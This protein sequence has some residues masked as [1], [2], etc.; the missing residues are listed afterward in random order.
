MRAASRREGMESSSHYHCSASTITR[1][2]GRGI[3]AASAYRAGERIKDQRTGLCHDYTRKRGVLHS[4]IVT[5]ADA[6]AWTQDRAQLW[7]AAERAEDSST[8]RATAKTGREFRLAF[9]HQLTAE[10]RIACAREFARYLVDA[11][12]IAVDFSIHAPDRNGDQRNFHAHVLTSTRVMTDAGFGDKVRVLDRPKTSSKHIEAIRAQ[13]AEIE[14]A[15]YARAGIDLRVDYR[16]YERRGIDQSGTTHLGPKAS[17]LER[18]GQSSARGDHNRAVRAEN[19]AREKLKLELER[20]RLDAQIEAEEAARRRRA[21]ARAERAAVRTHDPAS[22][23]VAITDK[24][25]TFSEAE[26]RASLRRSITDEAERERLVRA[27]LRR[28]ELV[29]LAE[30]QG[31]TI[32]RYTTKTVLQH[33]AEGLSAAASLCRNHRHGVAAA[34]RVSVIE[35]GRFGSISP[36]QYGAFVSATGAEGLAVIAGEAGT[37]KSYTMNAIRQAYEAEGGRVVGLSFTNKVVQDLKRDGFTEVRTIT[38]ALQDVDRGRAGWNA[39]TVLMV[40]EAAMLSTNDMVALLSTAQQ[41]GAKVVLVG[42]E[43]QLG[44][45]YRRGGLFGA[46]CAQDGTVTAELSEIRR[47]KDSAPGAEQQRAAFNA[48]HDGRFR[49]ALEI[50]DALGAIHWSGSPEEAR[51]ALAAQ[52]ALDVTERPERRRFAFTHSNADAKAVNEVLRAVHRARGELGD[53]IL[54]PTADGLT[55]FAT[56]DRIQ[57]TGSAYRKADRDAGLANGMVG[58]ISAIDGAKLTVA[59]DG[60]KGESGR[61]LSFVVGENA[62]AGEFNAFRHGYAGT[63]Y[64]GQGATVDDAYR[65]HSGMERAATSYVGA[66][67]H[68]EHLHLFV[69]RDILPGVEPWMAGR[70]GLAALSEGNRESAERSYASWSAAHP[71]WGRLYGLADYVSYTQERWTPDKARAADLD[72]LARQMGRP[73]E[74]R[75]ASQFVPVELPPEPMAP[76]DAP[77]SRYS[78]LLQRTVDAFDLIHRQTMRQARADRQ[79]ATDD[80]AES[81]RRFERLRAFWDNKIEHFTQWKNQLEVDIISHGSPIS[82]EPQKDMKPDVGEIDP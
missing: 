81:G 7:N 63:V 48:M 16:S 9:A 60:K 62:Q 36:E 35:R 52:Y 73:E 11:Y 38:G 80:D 68:A 40:D 6:P 25:A 3:V 44:S 54:L 75:A 51:A 71:A 66:T 2:Q 77:A 32:T 59:L 67:R 65:L 39:R 56:G 27:I 21:E 1:A 8:R 55:P 15:A 53:D 78:P 37:G 12:G 69:S 18:G 33:E 41:A 24:R 23:L 13:W 43:R 4:E 5:P 46:I 31:G 50:F 45:A 74:G 57:F 28:P 72:Q 26:L 47:I 64:K 82:R 76:Q 79:G 30:R 17:G 70:D 29:G 22:I 58:S 19:A 49:D 34:T 20:A 10:E 14:N 42:D 61:M